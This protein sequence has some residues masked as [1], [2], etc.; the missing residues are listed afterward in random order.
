MEHPAEAHWRPQAPS[1]WLLD[2]VR[3]ILS[4]PGAEKVTVAQCLYGCEYEKPT[5]F[6][7]IH[8]PSLGIKVREGPGG[9]GATIL[10]GIVRPWAV[11]RWG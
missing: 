7:T 4:S 3:Y 2:E 5:T 8:L 1:S 10:V 11:G 9:G 6:L